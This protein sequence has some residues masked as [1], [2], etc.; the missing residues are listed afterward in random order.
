MKALGSKIFGTA[1][2]SNVTPM[3]IVTTDISRWARQTVKEFTLGLT[4]KS[5]TENGFKV[6]NRAMAFGEAC[7]MTHTLESG[8]SQKLMGMAFTLGKTETDMRASGT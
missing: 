2:L 4:V 6:L 5:T 1:R 7:T 3:A 8:S